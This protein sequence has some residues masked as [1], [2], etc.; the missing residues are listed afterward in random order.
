MIRPP[1]NFYIR[2]FQVAKETI[3]QPKGDMPPDKRT[4]QIISNEYPQVPEITIT[5]AVE[6]AIEALQ[7]GYG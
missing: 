2:V 1:R 3:L 5:A 6:M 7:K 4:V